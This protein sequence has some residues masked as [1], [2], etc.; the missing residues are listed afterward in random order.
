M[1]IFEE[2]GPK[3]AGGSKA[4]RDVDGEQVNAAIDRGLAYLAEHQ[5][6]NGEF[7]CYIAID[8]PMQGWC[9]T[10]STVFATMV[11]ASCLVSTE[12]HPASEHML[13]KATIY[14]QSQQ[15]HGPTWPVFSDR[16]RWHAAVPYDSD[17]LAYASAFLQARGIVYPALNIP[18]LLANRN[19]QGLF[20]TWFLL[21]P[22]WPRNRTHLRV[23]AKRLLHPLR[24]IL[25]WRANECDPDD[26]DMGI[27]ANILYYLGERPETLP[28]VTALLRVIVEGR[29]DDCDKWYR[30]RFSIYYLIARAYSKGAHGLAPARDLIVERILATAQR[31]GS[32]GTSILDT[33]FAVS[34][35]LLLDAPTAQVHQAVAALLDQQ[36]QAGNW[37]RWLFYY[38]GPQRSQG[39]GSEELTTGFCLEAVAL[40]RAKFGISV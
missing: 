15:H 39:W 28:I 14:M 19:R 36:T 33:A 7:C 31:D 24:N 38:G 1:L 4:Q 34:T 13:R 11:V 17:S 35:L 12:A 23:T 40:Y 29:E 6:P 5:Y 27:N 32:F 26:V 2:V 30:N 8:E 10:D 9:V 21:R 25:F 20:L 22:V 3:M 16:H 37:V 18:L